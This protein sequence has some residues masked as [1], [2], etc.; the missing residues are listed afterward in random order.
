MLALALPNRQHDSPSGAHDSM[1]GLH[2]C[3]GIVD[4]ANAVLLKPV[5]AAAAK[6][7]LHDLKPGRALGHN[8]AH[9]SP[10]SSPPSPPAPPAPPPMPPPP[11]PITAAGMIPMG[12]A[13]AV[14]VGVMCCC[15]LVFGLKALRDKK[16]GK[17]KD[18]DGK[19]DGGGGDAPT[20]RHGPKKFRRRG[21][22]DVLSPERED[23]VRR[24]ALVAQ[25][26][27][28]SRRAS[29]ICSGDGSTLEES[30]TATELN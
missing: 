18:G 20:P 14:V 16:K 24:E 21:C 1:D 28:A 5:V 12:P 25:I 2:D 4:C 17:G 26:F 11:P 19:D 27:H 8:F 30:G 3:A 7:F 10:P 6:S 13:L 23:G 29:A 15:C 22:T 9:L